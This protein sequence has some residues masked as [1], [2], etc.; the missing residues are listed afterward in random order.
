MIA[1]ICRYMGLDRDRCVREF[2]QLFR[3]CIVGGLSFALY[4]GLY[5]LFSRV[6]FVDVNR[7]ILNFCANVLAAIPN[8][9]AHQKFTYKAKESAGLGFNSDIAHLQKYSMVLLSGMALNS[10]GFWIG[11]ERLY[12]DDKIVVIVMALVVPIYTYIMHRQ[13]TF[14]SGVRHQTVDKFY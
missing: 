9:L 3:F 6:L 10:A 14:R 2:W 1:Y 13:F 4:A 11:H 5:A 8:F 12:I 7:T